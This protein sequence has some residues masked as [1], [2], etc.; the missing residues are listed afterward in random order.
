MLP[1]K[2]PLIYLFIYQSR[3]QT[4]HDTDCCRM[5]REKDSQITNNALPN[6][7][8]DLPC[9]FSLTRS[10]WVTLN[11]GKTK[12]GRRGGNV[13]KRNYTNGAEY[14]YGESIQAMNHILCSCPLGST[15]SDMDPRTVNDTALQ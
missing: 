15:C 5:K 6:P 3:S 10:K 4:N 13:Q 9:G 11:R 12:V 8:Q 1:S 2:N 7:R 14:P